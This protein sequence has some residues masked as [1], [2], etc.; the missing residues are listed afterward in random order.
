MEFLRQIFGPSKEEAWRAL[1]H[2]IGAEFVDGGLWNGD[3]V[4]ARVNQWTITLDT[5]T[6]SHGKSSTTYTRIRAP[7]VNKDGFR[8]KIYRSN[9]F[10]KI[11]KMF[12]MEDIKVGDTLFDE[13]FI[14]KGNDRYKVQALFAND[15]IRG[16]IRAQQSIHLQVKSTK[17]FY[18][19]M[20]HSVDE[21]YFQVVGVI[22]NVRRLRSLFELFAE[23]LNTVCHLDTAYVN[24]QA[25]VDNYD[26]K[27]TQPRKGTEGGEVV[28]SEEGSRTLNG[29]VICPVC[30]LPAFYYDDSSK[31]YCPA[32]NFYFRGRK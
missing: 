25:L 29:D 3:K 17:D 12:G 14:I 19:A 24:D 18:G 26:I 16:L 5:Y 6:V 13:E 10:A 32:C 7:Y 28:W 22:K 4:V 15:R 27:G 20:S 1:C 31:M 9:F 11:G 30:S 2:Q 8:F 23:I 21:L